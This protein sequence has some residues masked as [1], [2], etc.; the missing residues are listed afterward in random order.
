MIE[1][2]TAV[3]GKSTKVEQLP[4]VAVGN[5][6]AIRFADG[7]AV[8][9]LSRLMHILVRV[10]HRVQNAVG[11]DL[12]YHIDQSR[13]AKEA[14]DSAS[15]VTSLSAERLFSKCDHRCA[16]CQMADLRRGGRESL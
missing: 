10:V 12:R 6:D 2:T 5:F 4:R 16:K 11:T 9:P 8:E 15:S 14:A 13:C 1:L 7:S 3:S